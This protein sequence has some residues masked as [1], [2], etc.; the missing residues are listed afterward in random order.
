MGQST[1]KIIVFDAEIVSLDMVFLTIFFWGIG[2]DTE[3]LLVDIFQTMLA[4][5]HA[6]L[7]M[8]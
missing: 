4:V 8:L 5:E 7:P 6:S 3:R 2:S 1:F